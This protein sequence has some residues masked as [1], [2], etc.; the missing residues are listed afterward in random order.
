MEKFVGGRNAA[1]LP[2]WAKGQR[3]NVQALTWTECP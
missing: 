3:T 2:F 1:F